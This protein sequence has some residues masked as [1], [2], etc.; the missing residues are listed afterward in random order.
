MAI[1]SLIYV[2]LPFNTKIIPL[3]ADIWI[4]VQIVTAIF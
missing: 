4:S 3:Q 2:F 1:R